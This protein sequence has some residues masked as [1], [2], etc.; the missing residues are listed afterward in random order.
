MFFA[1]KIRK[2]SY[3]HLTQSSVY[4]Y[5]DRHFIVIRIKPPIFG[6]IISDTIRYNT[7]GYTALILS[8]RKHDTIQR[9]I[10]RSVTAYHHYRAIAVISHSTR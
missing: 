10:H 4:D 8:I 7:H 2:D 9:I 3:I 1:V 6:E 5:V